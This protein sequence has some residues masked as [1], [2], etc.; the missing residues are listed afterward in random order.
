[1]LH[2]LS[3]FSYTKNV[4][5]WYCFKKGPQEIVR[6]TWNKIWG[7]VCFFVFF[8]FFKKKDALELWVILWKFYISKNNFFLRFLTSLRSEPL[9]KKYNSHAIY[10]ITRDVPRNYYLSSNN[11]WKFHMVRLRG[12]LVKLKTT[13]VDW[14]L[15]FLLA[16]RGNFCFCSDLF[17]SKFYLAFFY[18]TI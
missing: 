13:L 17:L 12:R 11:K 8:V 9:R 10:Y 14:K 3:S 2:S 7:L 4:P 18:L 15:T 6:I 16:S 5:R 1:M